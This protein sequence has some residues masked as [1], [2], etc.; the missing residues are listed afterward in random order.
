MN[1]IIFTSCAVFNLYYAVMVLIVFAVVI[2]NV[3]NKTHSSSSYHLEMVDVAR[4]HLQESDLLRS[5]VAGTKRITKE[6][7]LCVPLVCV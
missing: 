7:Q 4:V 3:H 6:N 2:C 1:T 5:Q